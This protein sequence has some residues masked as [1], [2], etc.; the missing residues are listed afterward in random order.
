MKERYHKQKRF[1]IVMSSQ[2]IK[3]NDELIAGGLLLDR[4]AIEL[5]SEE[6][7]LELSPDGQKEPAL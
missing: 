2:K 4:V 7:L 3:Q 1:Q 5:L 6:E